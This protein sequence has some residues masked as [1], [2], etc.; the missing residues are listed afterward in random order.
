MGVKIRLSISQPFKKGQI[1]YGKLLISEY[2]ISTFCL[3]Y[4]AGSL[5]SFL[6][7]L[8][9]K[10]KRRRFWC[11]P[12]WALP[13][14]LFSLRH[15]LI[16]QL[17]YVLKRPVLWYV[18]FSSGTQKA[19]GKT[20]RKTSIPPCKRSIL[21]VKTTDF[22]ANVFWHWPCPAI[23]DRTSGVDVNS[24]RFRVAKL[25]SFICIQSWDPL[26]VTIW[27]RSDCG[28]LYGQHRKHLPAF[29]HLLMA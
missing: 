18:K 2:T 24:A 29:V 17:V 8:R 12:N 19:E 6:L 22:G 15:G 14:A 5:I 11:N 13:T 16:N 21:T 23:F 25:N 20:K 26:H 9:E 28:F 4:V 3:V 27:I 7:S 10:T 1:Q